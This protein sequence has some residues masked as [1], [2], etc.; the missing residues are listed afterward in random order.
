M[1]RGAALVALITS[2][3]AACASTGAFRDKIVAEQAPVVVL[4]RPA[5]FGTYSIA[6]EGVREQAEA[7]GADRSE[8]DE[9]GRVV[10]EVFRDELGPERVTLLTEPPPERVM[11]DRSP[12]P[13]TDWS[14]HAGSVLVWVWVDG[15]FRTD[16]DVTGEVSYAPYAST[17]VRFWEIEPDMFDFLYPIGATAESMGSVGGDEFTTD[18]PLPMEE[19]MSRYDLDQLRDD[20]TEATRRATHSYLDEVRSGG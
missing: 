1:L 12:E 7:P 4:L 11:E 8:W 17:V 20:L 6:A 18:E 16:R 5:E 9:V 10:Y 3:L 14:E 2:S 15:G 19:V 13:I